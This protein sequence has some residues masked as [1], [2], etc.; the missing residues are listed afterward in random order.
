MRKSLNK[1]S[2]IRRSDMHG[3]KNY[4]LI[5]KERSEALKVETICKYCEIK[6]K[7]IPSLNPIYCSKVCLSRDKPFT[8]KDL[9]KKGKA[10]SPDTWLQAKLIVDGKLTV[11]SMSKALLC[12]VNDLMK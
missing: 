4:N 5:Q 1:V 8:R 12:C 11:E 7:H 6:F 10:H 3:S 2:L 9:C